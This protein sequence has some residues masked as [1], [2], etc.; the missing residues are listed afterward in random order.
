MPTLSRRSV[1]FM[2]NTS[3]RF[4]FPETG[5]KRRNPWLGVSEYYE[6]KLQ[7]DR[8]KKSDAFAMLWS[9]RSRWSATESMTFRPSPPP[10]SASPSARA[11]DLACHVGNVVL[12]SD[13]LTQ[14]PWLIQLS[15][16]TRRL[17]AQ[18][19]AWAA[20]YNAIA[21]MAAAGGWLHP[22]LAAVAMVISSLTVLSNSVRIRN[23]PDP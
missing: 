12:L 8:R 5:S 7:G 9:M 23:F 17:I 6:P 21:L 15:R 10:T 14:I 4:F 19:L 2:M 13:R 1:N 11:Q 3:R 18:N 22:L 20:G 16:Y